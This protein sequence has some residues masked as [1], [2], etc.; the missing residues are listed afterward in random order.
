MR[1]LTL[2]ILMTLTLLSQDIPESFKNYKK[3]IL[4]DDG[5]WKV[6]LY[7]SPKLSKNAK[8]VNNIKDFDDESKKAIEIKIGTQKIKVSFSIGQSDDPAFIFRF[9]NL[10][11]YITI[12]CDTKLFV[13]KSG[14][15]YVINGSNTLYTSYKKYKLSKNE[16]TEVKQAFYKISKTCKTSTLAKL[17]S[18]KC[19][20][21]TLVASI[22]KGRKVQIL[23]ADTKD[24]CSQWSNLREYLVETSF[25]LVGWVTSSEGYSPRV[26]KPLSCL[27]YQGD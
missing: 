3:Y 23:L 19:Q 7:L 1:Q 22:P 4:F 20:K 9:K 6:P 2:L 17:Y 14:F 10:K 18:K 24:S 26:G 25:G 15:I 27:M 11:D 5:L 21:G 16:I 13:S 12:D 8:I